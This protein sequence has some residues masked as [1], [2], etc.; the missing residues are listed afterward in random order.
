M[1]QSESRLRA[2]LVQGS[3]TDCADSDLCTGCLPAGFS[4]AKTDSDECPVCVACLECGKKFGPRDSV[5]TCSWSGDGCGTF[6]HVKCA[7][8]FG[9]NTDGKAVCPLCGEDLS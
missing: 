2:D 6:Y 9:K 1:C 4:K 3:A 7:G 8:K 5:H